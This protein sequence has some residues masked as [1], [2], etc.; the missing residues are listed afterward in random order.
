MVDKARRNWC[1]FCRLQKCFI[2]GMN[3]AAVQN[4]RGPRN[5]RKLNTRVFIKKS[6]ILKLPTELRN[7]GNE[8]SICQL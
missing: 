2:V 7:K 4:E 5:N 3:A 8:I 6:M 1:P